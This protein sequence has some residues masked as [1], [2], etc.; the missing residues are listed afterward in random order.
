MNIFSW[1]NFCSSLILNGKFF[2]FNTCKHALFWNSD[3]PNFWQ[4]KYHVFFFFLWFQTYFQ[5]PKYLCITIFKQEKD[6][7]NKSSPTT[8]KTLFWYYFIYAYLCMLFQPNILVCWHFCA[9]LLKQHTN[10]GLVV[11]QWIFWDISSLNDSKGA[12]SALRSIT[13]EWM[14]KHYWSMFYKK[15][16]SFSASKYHI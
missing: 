1:Q 4:Q 10:T 13:D 12:S 5:L 11:L 3:A 8:T 9:S 15:I 6:I 14:R 2:F 16:V 7:S